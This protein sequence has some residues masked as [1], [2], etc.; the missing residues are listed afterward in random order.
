[1]ELKVDIYKGDRSSVIDE[2]RECFTYQKSQLLS[3]K[4]II[5]EDTEEHLSSLNQLEESLVQN[6]YDYLLKNPTVSN[7]KSRSISIQKRNTVKERDDNT[8][9]ICEEKF[10]EDKLEADHIFPHSLGGSNQIT[11]LMALCRPC[12]ENKGNRLEYYKSEEGKQKLLQN[13]REFVNN[14]RLISNFGEWLMMA[15]DAR[16]KKILLKEEETMEF[17]DNEEELFEDIYID[18]EE[19][20]RPNLEV[21]ETYLGFLDDPEMSTEDIHDRFRKISWEAYKFSFLVD[22]SQEEKEAGAQIIK[23]ICKELTERELIHQFTEILY[24][25]TKNDIFIEILKSNCFNT[26]IQLYK[27]KKYNGYLIELLDI[28]GYFTNI[29]GEILQA[30]D[31]KNY[32]LLNKFRAI[33]LNAYKNEGLELVKFL[34][35]KQKE[36]TKSEDQNLR[37]LISQIIENIE[38]TYS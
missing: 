29:E 19:P 25:L 34:N 24:V 32:D 18:E 3:L 6:I 35:S 20:R 31:D 33:R 9:Q 36:L 38:R 37:G 5:I 21:I 11:N 15:G 8:C 30:I 26:F 16:R 2:F 28:C 12:N 7:T 27:E 23:H 13:I 1:M 10:S 17:K 14:L 4:N 22:I